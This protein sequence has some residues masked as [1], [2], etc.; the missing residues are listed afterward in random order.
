MTVACANKSTASFQISYLDNNGN[1]NTTLKHIS[2]LPVHM[3]IAWEESLGTLCSGSRL[4]IKPWLPDLYS[5]VFPTAAMPETSYLNILQISSVLRLLQLL[6]LGGQEKITM[7]LS[8]ALTDLR[9]CA[10]QNC[11]AFSS[12]KLAMPK[13]NTKLLSKAKDLR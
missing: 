8:C 4:T 11:I 9:R 12:V 10:L 3:A 13:K 7:V 1:E 5:A 2:R 6:P